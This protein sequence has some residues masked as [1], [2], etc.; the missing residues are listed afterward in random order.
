LIFSWS[1]SI[2]TAQ[3]LAIPAQT[4]YLAVTPGS[5]LSSLQPLFDKP[6]PN[7]PQQNRGAA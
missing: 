6:G 5:D 4:A 3:R 7:R 2:A 1:G